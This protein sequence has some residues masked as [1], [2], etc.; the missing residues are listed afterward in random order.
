MS[1]FLEIINELKRADS[2]AL[3]LSDMLASEQREIVNSMKKVQSSFGEQQLC[4][5]FVGMLYQ[6][7][8]SLVF[9]EVTLRAVKISLRNYMQKIQK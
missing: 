8:Q 4:Q 3:M 2:E 9:A 1:D 7:L 5:Q 6:T